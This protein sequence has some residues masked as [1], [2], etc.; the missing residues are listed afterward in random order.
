MSDSYN[1]LYELL[2]SQI[3]EFLG[4]IRYHYN[5]NVLFDSDIFK[6]LVLHD[7]TIIFNI[8]T[9]IRFRMNEPYLN[10]YRNIVFPCQHSGENN[11]NV[12]FKTTQCMLISNKRKSSIFIL[13]N[14]K[15][16]R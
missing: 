13:K 5:A 16:Q 12:G 3:E 8:C 4:Q 1:E 2:E 14:H 11:G 10:Y 7:W 6:V 9:C 15:I